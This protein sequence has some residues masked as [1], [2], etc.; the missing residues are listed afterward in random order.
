M[1]TEEPVFF[2]DEQASYN[3]DMPPFF[4][5]E[6]YPWVSIL[7]DNWQII[8]NEFENYI[9]GTI[10]LE[11]SSVNPPYL[12]NPDGWQNQY[13]WNF[14]WKKHTNCKRFP[15]TYRLLQSVPNLIF[16]EFTCLKPKSRV[17]PHIGETNVTIRG[18]LGIEVPEKLPIM[19]IQVKDQIKGWENGK[20]VLFSDAHRHT[21]W[22]D[23]NKPRFVLVFDVLQDEYTTNRYWMC[24]KALSALS[25]KYFDEHFNLLKRLPNFLLQ[26]IHFLL[27]IAWV[28][29]LPIQNKLSFLP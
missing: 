15:K 7:E 14:L 29:Y 10:E 26:S 28:M 24:A 13:F 18:H 17:L 16:A 9:N 27:S 3:G 23:S 11:K 25:I 8:R 19:G 12:S 20:V 21:V 4:Q 5:K 6:K 22:N 1:E 2:L